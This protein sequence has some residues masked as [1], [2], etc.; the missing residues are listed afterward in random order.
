MVIGQDN[1]VRL[2]DIG[3]E[4]VHKMPDLGHIGELMAI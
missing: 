4:R 3:K 2:V 1:I